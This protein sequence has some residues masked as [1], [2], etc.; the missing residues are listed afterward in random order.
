MKHKITFEMTTLE[1]RQIKRVA[2]ARKRGDCDGFESDVAD[3]VLLDLAAA[4]K[5]QTRRPNRKS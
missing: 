5:S 1:A 3:Q 2:D 4:F